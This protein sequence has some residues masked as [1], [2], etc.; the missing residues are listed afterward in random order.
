MITPA[1][2]QHETVD[3]GLPSGTLWA[4]TDI[5]SD[6]PE[7]QGTLLAWGETEPKDDYDMIT[8]KYYKAGWVK[9]DNLD[10][11][12]TGL[13][14]YT[15]DPTKAYGQQTDSLTVLEDQDDA[16]TVLWGEVWQ[17][18][19]AENYQELIDN[20][21]WEKVS[22]NG[23]DGYK[24]VGPNGNWLFFGF[25]GYQA[26]K[27][28]AIYDTYYLTKAKS[29]TEDMYYLFCPFHKKVHKEFY[30][31]QGMHARAIR[32][33]ATIEE[34]TPKA[35]EESKPEYP[36][37]EVALYGFINKNIKYPKM[38]F[39]NNIEGRVVVG[40]TVVKDG[41]ISDVHII[42]SVDSLIDKEAIRVVKMLPGRWKPGTQGGKAVNVKYAVTIKFSIR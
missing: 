20:C 19:T 24:V 16:A 6:C 37:G 3:L 42:R 22:L 5:G 15:C 33:S 7:K 29:A 36:G 14:K 40:F 11:Y 28:H 25:H 9:K 34:D 39:E 41:T 38:A 31:Y 30:Y 2:S 10:Y 27:T 4:K 12:L 13:T 26:G 23:V 17:L 8:H 32:K 35:I 18:P 21:T 1:L